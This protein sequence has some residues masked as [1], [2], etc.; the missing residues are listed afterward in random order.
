[1][2]K[3]KLHS[4]NQTK[5]KYEKRSRRFVFE[6]VDYKCICF[7]LCSVKRCVAD[8][9]G[10]RHLLLCRV[11]LGR[12]ELVH[13]CAEQCNPSCEDYDSGV[14][15]FSEPKKYIIWSSRMN[16]HV[17]P[18]YVISFRV[19]SLKGLDFGMIFCELLLW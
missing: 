18:A 12:S 11:I 4:V 3:K 10:V 6:C 16:T 14:D 2:N 7:V 9:D 19:P 1:M 15:S 17:L 5:P 13:P 8:K